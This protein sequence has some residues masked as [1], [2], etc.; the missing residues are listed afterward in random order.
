MEQ[1]HAEQRGAEA[2]ALGHEI[3]QS[4][5]RARR[6]TRRRAVGELHVCP[7]C[8]SDLVY[9][10]AWESAERKRWAVSLRCPECE[11]TGGG[12]Y[13]QPIIGRFDEALDRGTDQVLRD[14]K[15]LTQANMEGE[16]DRFV[17]AL[18]DGHILPEDF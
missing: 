10:T 15:L 16:I 7:S 3:E 13:G 14:L 6:R 12:V 5:F 9:P 17:A 8:G 4:S 18:A 2:Q 11:W 1:P